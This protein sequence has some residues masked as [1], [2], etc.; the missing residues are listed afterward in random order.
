MRNGL[1]CTLCVCVL[2]SGCSLLERQYVTVEPHSGKFWESEAAGTLRAEN[3]QDIVNDLLLLIGQH[4][5]T[6]TLRLY[7]FDNDVTIADRLEQAT[8]EIQQQ[9]PLGSYAVSYIASVSQAQRGYYEIKLQIGYRRTAEELQ[10]IVSATSPEAVYTLLRNAL[11]RQQKELAVRIGYWGPGGE[12]Q[13]EDAKARLREDEGLSAFPDWPE[14]FYYPEQGP[15]GLLE[16]RLDLPEPEAVP[17]DDPGEETR[18]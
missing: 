15:V 3:Y 4:R 5:E 2:L 10:A 7:H 1:L 18:P 9:T 6:A 16:F 8:M 11:D 12:T 14:T 17:S 13:V